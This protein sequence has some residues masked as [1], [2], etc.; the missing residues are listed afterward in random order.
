MARPRALDVVARWANGWEASYL[1]PTDFVILAA[2]RALIPGWSR[3]PWGGDVEAGLTDLMLAFA[4]FPS[5]TLLQRFAAQ[6]LPRSLSR[7]GQR[8]R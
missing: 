6:V 7:G 8:R 1:N 3:Q 5:T 2:P 4:D